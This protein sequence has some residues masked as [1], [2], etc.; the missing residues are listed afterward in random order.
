MTNGRRQLFRLGIRQKVVLIL[1]TV[2]LT[3]LSI[4]GYL[5]L[6]DVERNVLDETDRR[7]AET[8]DYL[9]RS[10]AYPVVGYD[11]HTLQLLLEQVV[12][13]GGVVHVRVISDRGNTMAEMQHPQREELERVA[14]ERPI[15]LDDRDVG[16]LEME[17]SI[18]PILAQLQQQKRALIQREV[19]VI[20]LIAAAEFIALSWIIIGPLTRVSRSLESNVDENGVILRDIP[21]GSRDEIG[22]LARRFNQMRAQLNTANEQLRGRVEAADRELKEAY[23]QLLRQQSE[24]EASNMELEQLTL[25]DPLTGLGNRRAFQEAIEKDVALFRRHGDPASLLILDLDAF[26]QINDTHGHEGGDRIL[27]RFAELLQDRVRTT[28]LVCRLGGEEFAVFLRRAEPEDALA[29]AEAL[30]E[31]VAAMEVALDDGARASI[32]VSIGV[33]WLSLEDDLTTTRA[34]CRA[35]DQAMYA[36]KRRGRNRVTDYTTLAAEDPLGQDQSGDKG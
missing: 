18:E 5:V 1:L 6:R 10:L 35:A 30:R 4:S 33:A 2:L 28:D 17:L 27:R 23:D 36:S 24:L 34:L 14:F 26:K 11:Y 7:G 16:Y 19:A 13:A 12:E 9:A 32:T 21:V 15:M 8:A 25:T 29:I 31:A 3:A 22:E 20:A